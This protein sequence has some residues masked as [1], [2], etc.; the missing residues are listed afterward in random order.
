MEHSVT[1]E[2]SFFPLQSTEFKEEINK[3]IE[4]IRS[5]NL[6]YQI[7]LLSTT[8]KGE[9]AVVFKMVYKLFSTM[10]ENGKFVLNVKYANF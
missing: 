5:F 7:S 2:I 3:A 1:A 9:Q 10:S 8:V 6:E 4:V